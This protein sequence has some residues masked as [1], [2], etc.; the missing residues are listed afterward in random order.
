MTMRIEEYTIEPRCD[1]PADKV[2]Y[3]KEAHM[4]EMH[5]PITY[6]Y[7]YLGEDKISTASTREQAER[8]RDWTKN[9]LTGD[10]GE[11]LSAMP[12]GAASEHGDRPEGEARWGN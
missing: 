1:C 10:G 2:G 12:V 7:V 3:N 6:W 5:L 11:R 4:N 9:W 8:T